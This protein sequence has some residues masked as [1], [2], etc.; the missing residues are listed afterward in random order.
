MTV[1]VEPQIKLALENSIKFGHFIGANLA[2]FDYKI[3]D[4]HGS[5]I[6]KNLKQKLGNQ[7]F[8]TLTIS[9]DGI[10]VQDSTKEKSVWP[11]QFFLNEVQLE[12]RFKREYILCSAFSFGK[13]PK[14][15]TFMRP[16]I[17]E[18]NRINADGGLYVT[19]SLTGQD[20]RF[21][22]I[23]LSVTTDSVAKCYVIEKTQFNGHFGCPYCLHPG[24]I[25][26]G[27]KQVKYC[28]QDNANVR[29][30]EDVKQ[31]MLEA[32]GTGEIIRGYRNISALLAL[33]TDFDIVKQTVID[34]MHS[35]DLGVVKKLFTIWFDTKN[36]NKP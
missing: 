25:L 29:S 9:T 11:L 10:A 28:I 15:S 18:I 23:P 4:V 8:V 7:K 35:L 33:H 36:R 30:H 22:I 17:E 6:Y 31:A 27:S 3:C 16:F 34:K 1:P 5:N 12:H 20:E 32:Y 24:T 21:M 14:M 13:T 2:E 19:N 26:P